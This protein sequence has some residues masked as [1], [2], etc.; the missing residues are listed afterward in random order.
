MAFP[1]SPDLDRLVPSFAGVLMDN[2][3]DMVLVL[4]TTGRLVHVNRTTLD[5][6]GYTLDELVRG[7]LEVFLSETDAQGVRRY[8][9][10]IAEG[11][12]PKVL[13]LGATTKTL[14]KLTLEVVIGPLVNSSNRI[15]GA[16]LRAKD[17][18]ERKQ[19]EVQLEETRNFIEKV[20]GGLD[21]GLVTVDRDGGV[22]RWSPGMERMLLLSSKEMNGQLFHAILKDDTQKRRFVNKLREAIAGRSLSDMEY[23]HVDRNDREVVIGI[24]SSPLYDR[25]GRVREVV[26]IVKDLTEKKHLE[27]RLKESE[28]RL[29]TEVIKKIE[30]LKYIEQLNRLVVEYMEEGALL[31]DPTRDIGFVNPKLVKLLGYTIEELIGR[32][33]M[34]IVPEDLLWAWNEIPERS[35]RGS[36]K[37]ESSLLRKDGEEVPVMVTSSSIKIETRKAEVLC[38]I[39]DLSEQKAKEERMREELMEFKLKAGNIYLLLERGYGKA[40]DVLLTLKRFGHRAIIVS[41]RTNREDLNE[42]IKEAEAEIFWLEEKGRGAWALAPTKEALTSFVERKVDRTKVL[43]LDRCD[44]L[45]S[46]LGFEGLRDLIHGL[47]DIFYHKKAILVLLVEPGSL[48]QQQIELLEKDASLVEAKRAVILPEDLQELLVFIHQQNRLGIEPSYKDIGKRFDITKTTTRKRVQQLT[49][50]DMVVETK[51]G[52]TKVLR[53]T[54]KG[55]RLVSTE[56]R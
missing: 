47:V 22:L 6:L 49:I 34:L 26:L 30:D 37:F 10:E 41:R 18:T 27:E 50:L 48:G 23:A 7:G 56:N 36:Y 40:M 12:G 52:R 54:D 31:L 13:A 38:T 25:Q 53:V 9:N 1:G 28:K 42:I 16:W 5:L 15:I 39:I 33:L 14:G 3:S 17:V 4:D 43:L 46:R 29:A 44:Y 8:T 11:R 21:E 35:K 55:S 51:H 2:L 24:S 45:C 32:S 20:V 19:F